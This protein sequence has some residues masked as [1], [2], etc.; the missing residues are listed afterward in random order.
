MT[1]A[2]RVAA[3]IEVLDTVLDGQ[4]AEQALSQW[5]RAHRFAGSK[6][7][8][9][10]RDLVFDVLRRRRSYAALGGGLTGRGL[11]I[12]QCVAGA[13]AVDAVFSGEGYAPTALSDAEQQ[14]IAAPG[15]L[16]QADALD[17]PDWILTE[18]DVVYGDKAAQICN[19]LRAR[20]PLDLRVN[21]R[22]ASVPSAQAKL[23]SDGVSAEPIPEVPGALRV[24]EG[25]RRVAH[26]DAYKTGLVEIQDA[27]SQAAALA[28]P[29][30]ASG[31]VLDFC[32]GGGGKAL[33]LAARTEATI[34]VHDIAPARM[35]DI[36]PRATRAGVAL[37]QWRDG[38]GG[39]DLVFCDAP[40]SGSGTW[41]RTPEAKWTLS[42]AR[43]EQYVTAQQEVLRNALPLV[44]PGGV[45]VYA[46]C[47][48]LPAE[49]MAQ[50]AWM[51][52]ALPRARLRQQQQMLP[53]APGD[54]FFYAIFDV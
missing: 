50:L 19:A 31:R 2:A 45:L 5:T 38:A 9:A 6:D 35:K 34:F 42:P 24:I 39:F 14:A 37:P 46:T 8:A 17:M 20:A 27:A 51:V 47:S 1:P 44:R 16:S 43:L 23:S 52:D 26:G 15:D 29:V 48:V 53:N 25:A 32:A 7:R 49:N 33:A 22:K 10:L 13:G 4:P 28:T 30:P 36:P 11:M 12:G 54:G 41:R 21:L 40:C 18:L 3:A